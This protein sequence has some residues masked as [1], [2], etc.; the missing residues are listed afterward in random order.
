MHG[1]SRPPARPSM[2]PSI[3]RLSDDSLY[4]IFELLRSWISFPGEGDVP[5]LRRP[6]RTINRDGNKKEMPLWTTPIVL[7][8]VCTRWRAF[9]LASPRLWNFI[10]VTGSFPNRI[11][12]H[13]FIERSQKCPLSILLTVPES[14]NT[15]VQAAMLVYDLLAVSSEIGDHG[16]RIR[17][18]AV[19][20]PSSAS[21]LVLE[22]L[23]QS[24]LPNLQKLWLDIIRGSQG[25]GEPVSLLN[26][27]PLSMR[28]F[29]MTGMTIDWLPFEGLVHLELCDGSAPTLPALLYTL[30]KSPR[31]EILKLQIY[32]SY[33]EDSVTTR[34]LP[35]NLPH[36]RTLCLTEY[37]GNNGAFAILPHISFPLTT[38]I[39]LHSAGRLPPDLC[40]NESL[41]QI[42]STV[43]RADLFLEPPERVLIK[44]DDPSIAMTY[45]G[46][47]HNYHDHFPWNTRLD[48]RLCEGFLA[49]AFPA[50]LELS[51]FA[52]E[53][54]SL[55]GVVSQEHFDLLFSVVPTITHL[56]LHIDPAYLP[57]I[58]LALSTIEGEGNEGGDL[59]C[60]KLRQW[61]ITWS[62]EPSIDDYWLV[63][64]C[65]ATRAAASVPVEE[66][67]T[68]A[69]PEIVLDNLQQAVGNILV[70]EG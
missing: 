65:C 57:A 7:S 23:A 42:S 45:P 25:G 8:H 22:D 68:T 24:A 51:I 17:E 43:D 37:N 14:K 39:G 50:L 60:P 29:R 54:D 3:E 34:E 46:V 30:R 38:E 31:L 49:V 19:V 21:R 32:R 2:P 62:R 13:H 64:R 35:V 9:V 47:F 15:H 67:E 56:R 61:A 59:R 10:R 48:P 36:L 20:L 66:L 69:V 41:R 58:A 12:L 18:L 1:T 70:L 63:E 55:R 33:S 53:V 44:T 5:C 26:I 28:V 40:E 4:A 6:A 16:E 11:M 27:N 52:V